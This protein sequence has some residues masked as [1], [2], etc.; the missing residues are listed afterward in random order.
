MPTLNSP[1]T[2]LNAPPSLPSCHPQLTHSRRFNRKT[3]NGSFADAAATK[4]NLRATLICIVCKSAWGGGEERCRMGSGAIWRSPHGIACALAP[5][6]TRPGRASSVRG[7][8]KCDLQFTRFTS[9]EAAAARCIVNPKYVCRHQHIV[10]ALSGQ[11]PPLPSFSSSP[12]GRTTF[13]SS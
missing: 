10:S 3:D 13:V 1:L 8:G 4:N 7:H 11:P 6:E 9:V 12:A 2:P 5:I